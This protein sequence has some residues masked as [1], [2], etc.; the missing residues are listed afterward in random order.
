MTAMNNITPPA[1]E[2]DR[3]VDPQFTGRWSPRAFSEAAISEADL[4]AL[5]E[6]ARWAPS[7]A[8]LQPWRLA[9]GLR[10]DAGFAAIFATLDAG[11]QVWAGRAAA[12]VAVASRTVR[13]TAKGEAVENP[14]HAFDAGAAWMSLALQAHLSGWAA[15]GMG[16]F[17]KAALASALHLP[18]DHALHAV[19]A[20][21][22]PGDP[23][24]L[25]EKLRAREIP[26]R[27]APVTNWAMRGRFAG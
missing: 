9:W 3:P 21:G 23:A 10:G 4:L 5:F 19:V 6:A 2:A 15:H 20:I 27:R 25:P 17:D 12:L 22:R 1:R 26:N 24:D 18:P 11:N 13:I 14:T 8:N 16:G 7:A